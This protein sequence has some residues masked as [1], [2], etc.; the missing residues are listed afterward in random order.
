[1]RSVALFGAIA[2]LGFVL[3][4]CDGKTSAVAGRDGATT[5]SYASVGA[6]AQVPA[7]DPRDLPTPTF[8]G[9]PL[10]A[11][12]RSHTAEENAAY[13]F[14]K[15]GADFNAKSESDYVGKAH[16][17]IDK[18][19]RDVETVDRANGDRL[20]YDPKGN[21]FVVEARNGAPR[22]M[23]KPHGGAAYWS[24]QKDREAKNAN[25]GGGSGQG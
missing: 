1:M 15:N 10:W 19:P 7:R 11:A 20:L 2:S 14:T 22:T 3:A 5:A 4:G 23:F 8:Q 16:A 24:E 9:K 12:N 6:G 13:Q 25:A 18:P 21:V 17:F